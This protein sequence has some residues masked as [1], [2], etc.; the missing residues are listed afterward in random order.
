MSSKPTTDMS[1]GTRRPI[2]SHAS[3][4][5]IAPMSF[6]TKNAVGAC[7]DVIGALKRNLAIVDAHRWR[8]PGFQ[9]KIGNGCRPRLR[10]V[11]L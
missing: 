4:K 10:I 1:A 8:F 11:F 6:D 5:P 2:A 3:I 9:T 7:G